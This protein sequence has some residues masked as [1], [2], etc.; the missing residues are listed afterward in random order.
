M[1][2]KGLFGAPAAPTPPPPPVMPDPMSPDVMAAKRKAMTDAVA[3]GRQ[4]TT[5]TTS[6]PLAAGIQAGAKLGG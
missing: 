4:S 1:S 3:S 6:S 2:L 5:L